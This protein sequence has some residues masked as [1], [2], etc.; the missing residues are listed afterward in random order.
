[1]NRIEINPAICSGKPVIRGTR[2][3]VRSIL[4]MIAGG[5]AADQIVES[6]PELSRE[7]VMAAVEYAAT[8]VDD[9]QVI[10]S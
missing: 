7:D 2:I 9:V 6:Y 4:G 8:V 10:G 1:M 3:M 5:Y